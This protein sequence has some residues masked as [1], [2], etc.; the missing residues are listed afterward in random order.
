MSALYV[1]TSTSVS[2][3]V[4]A[5]YGHSHSLLS[6]RSSAS[7]H[8]LRSH[9]L[10]DYLRQV[11]PPYTT[12]PY[13]N[14]DWNLPLRRESEILDLFITIATRSEA[15]LWESSLY[16]TNDA[17]IEDLF[18]QHQPRARLEDL[19]IGQGANRNLV[20]PLNWEKWQGLAAED[21]KV[22]LRYKSAAIR[23]M[24]SSSSTALRTIVDVV[25]GREESLEMTAKKLLDGLSRLS[26]IRN[27]GSRGRFY[28]VVY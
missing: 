13:P 3:F 21:V 7:M 19:I 15:H 5:A 22:D 11:R 25:R 20:F 1:V 17:A 6:P 12:N 14:L 28:Q 27:Q 23:L 8:L 26:L 9:H 2:A 4:L 10:S 16:L 24:T 18:A